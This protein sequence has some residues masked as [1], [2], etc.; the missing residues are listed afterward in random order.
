MIF[1]LDLYHISPKITLFPQLLNL[2]TVQIKNIL[3]LLT[4]FF[5]T[6]QPRNQLMY[7]FLQISHQ[8]YRDVTRRQR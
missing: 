3:E 2:F 4:A 7:V 8:L 6:P 5:R 1:L